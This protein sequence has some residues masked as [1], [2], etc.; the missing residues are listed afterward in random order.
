MQA[1]ANRPM[2]T[3]IAEKS[4]EYRV[5]TFRYDPAPLLGDVD[6]SGEVNAADRTYLARFLAGWSGYT[7]DWNVA[8]VNRDKV[9]TSTDRIH[10]ARY[11][12]GWEGV[13]LSEL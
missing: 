10:L 3:L 1:L 9:V 5:C 11:L 13:T 12:A 2:K 7:L 6:R 4:R 8:D